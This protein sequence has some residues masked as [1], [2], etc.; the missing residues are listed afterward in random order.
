MLTV[1][2]GVMTA[3]ALVGVACLFTMA[4]AVAMPAI[5]AAVGVARQGGAVNVGRLLIPGEHSTQVLYLV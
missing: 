3:S 2:V 1:G 4:F 5:A